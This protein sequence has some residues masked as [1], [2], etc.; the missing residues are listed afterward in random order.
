MEISESLLIV[1]AIIVFFIARMTW[2][3]IKGSKYSVRSIFIRPVI[4]IVLSAFLVLGLFLW[5]DA[6]V[7]IVAVLGVLL[8][9]VLGKRANIFE[10]NGQVMYKRSNEVTIL[11]LVAF[12]IRITIDFLF[13]PALSSA[14]SNE[15]L[16][17]I[18]TA[19]TTYESTPLAFGA[20]LL[21]AFSAG[22]LL[23][24]AFV[25]Y[26]NHKAKYSKA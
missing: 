21:L 7:I 1:V 26:R 8:G 2:R 10:K 14:A 18:L 11:W 6:L 22:L 17:T 5:Q 12:V 15:S 16:S 4:Y 3:T 9:L 25:L 20:D 24:E 23:G 13:N 19:M